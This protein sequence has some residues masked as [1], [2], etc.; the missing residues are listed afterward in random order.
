M[1]EPKILKVA[2]CLFD[3]VTTLDYLGSMELFGFLA[4]EWRSS[5]NINS[6]YS[7]EIRYVGKSAEINPTSGPRVRVDLTIEEAAKLGQQFDIIFVPG[8]I[9]ESF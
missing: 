7:F 5:L 2:V 3:G 8:G 1:S 6:E 9:S 4:P